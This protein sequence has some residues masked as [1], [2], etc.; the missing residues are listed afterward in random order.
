[1]T[2]ASILSEASGRIVTD[3]KSQFDEVQNLRRDLGVM[4]QVFTDFTRTTK[5]TLGQARAHTQQ[6]RQLANSKIG[7]ARAYIDSGKSSL[8]TR[9]QNVLTRVE[10]LQDTVEHLK[11]DVL[12]RFVSPRSQV[13]KTVTKDITE[14][15]AELASLKEYIGTVKPMWKKTWEEELQNIVE[16]QQFLQYQEDFLADLLDDHKALSEV[17]GHVEKVISLRGAGAAAKSR[18][19]KPPIP[20]DGSSGGLTNVMLEIRSAQVDPE[21]RLKAIEANKK[22][23]EKELASRSDDFEQELHTFVSGK[24]LKLTGGAEETER[25]RQKRNEMQLKAMF[26]ASSPS[27]SSLP[28]TGSTTFTSSEPSSPTG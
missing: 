1:M 23:R 3:L 19:F 18:G 21:R 27:L 16:E 14:S 20:E 24:K 4:R 2:G 5:E 8:D 12:K 17:F 13:F 28:S 15:G 26:N 22:N 7:G 9:T 11:D 25:L 6:V 10:E